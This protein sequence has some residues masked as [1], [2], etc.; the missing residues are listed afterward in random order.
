MSLELS[1]QGWGSC[2]PAFPL[3]EEQLSDFWDFLERLILSFPA[4]FFRSSNTRKSPGPAHGTFSFGEVFLRRCCSF[5][6]RI[7][8]RLHLLLID[9]SPV[10]Y[11]TI[12]IILR[13]KFKLVY[14]SSRI[15]IS[16]HSFALITT[17]YSL[18]PPASLDD[19]CQCS[20]K[21][22]RARAPGIDIAR[23]GRLGEAGGVFF[24]SRLPSNILCRVRTL[25]TT[26]QIVI[27][28][29]HSV[30]TKYPDS[31]ISLHTDGM[32]LLIHFN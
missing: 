23:R 13:I 16:C 15:D 5:L 22:G 14:V 20:Q 7:L 6:P 10:V 29:V 26:R 32:L 25:H 18:L 9:R 12:A 4:A 17:E 27:S 8:D 3:A 1:S 2:D 28:Q 30:R 21:P 31:G 11:A 19:S 24:M